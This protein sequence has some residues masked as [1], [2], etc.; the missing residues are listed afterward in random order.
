ML[1]AMHRGRIPPTLN[2]A[3]EDSEVDLDGNA[4]GVREDYVL[5]C[6]VNATGWAHNA[7]ISLAHPRAMRAFEPA[8]VPEVLPIPSEPI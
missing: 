6:L 7:A 4:S 5:V 3:E 1:E 8:D 2:L